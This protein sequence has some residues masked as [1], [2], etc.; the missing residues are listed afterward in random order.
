[1]A[2]LWRQKDAKGLL[3][4]LL[5]IKDHLNVRD[6]PLENLWGGGGGGASEVQKNIRAEKIKWKKIHPRQ[7]IL[8][9]YLFYGLKKIPAKNSPK[10]PLS[11]TI[12]FLMVGPLL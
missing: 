2:F 4:V 9:K 1:M 3:S 8:K 5:V 12:I 6:G 11:P 10:I 7:L